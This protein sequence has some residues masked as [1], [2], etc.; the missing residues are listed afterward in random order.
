MSE[1]DMQLI[2]QMLDEN[3]RA[4]YNDMQNMLQST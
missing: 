4:I 1:K 2:Q 3:R